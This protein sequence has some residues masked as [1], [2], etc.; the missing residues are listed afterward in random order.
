MSKQ[1]EQAKHLADHYVDQLS[2]WG[3]I[4]TRPLFGAVALGWLG[5]KP[6]EGIY[7][8][9]AQVFTLLYFAFFLVALPVLGLI[10]TPKPL[11][12]SISDAVL[13]EGGH[14][15]PAGAAAA[16]EKR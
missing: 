13:G 9:S 4:T 2:D 11:P 6:A 1:S 10:E 16:P 8:V 15:M 5:S 14:A 3:K 7:V 12:K